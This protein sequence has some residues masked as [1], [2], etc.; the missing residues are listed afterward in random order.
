MI[1]DPLLFAVALIDTGSL[2]FLLVYFVSFLRRTKIERNG[3]ETQISIQFS[4]ITK[5]KLGNHFV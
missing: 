2:L 3:K 5:Q 1:P 4:L